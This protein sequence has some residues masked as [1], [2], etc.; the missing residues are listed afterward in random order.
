MKP[1][2]GSAREMRSAPAGL[3]GAAAQ[4]ER[5]QRRLELHPQVHLAFPVPAL[6]EVDGQL[7]DLQAVPHRPVV[8]LDLEAVAVAANAG[9]VDGLQGGAAPDLEPRG[10]VANAE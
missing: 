1:S 4:L 10:D 8:H 3:A 6:G 2:S 7:D 9:D 5:H